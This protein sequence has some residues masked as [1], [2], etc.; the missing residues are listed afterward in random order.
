MK[1]L[2]LE[3]EP[4][5]RRGGQ[6]LSL[7][8]VCRGLAGHGHQIDL[9]YTCEG[10]LLEQYRTFCRSLIKVERYTVDRSNPVSSLAGVARGL[11]RLLPAD[12]DL[13]YFNQYHDAMFGGLLARM[14]RLPLV[15]HLRLFPPGTFCGQWRTG[16]PAVTRFIAVS[17]ATR[18]AYIQAGFAPETI[19]VVYNGIDL[20]R[21]ALADDWQATRAALGITPDAFVVIYVGRIDRPKN[22]E[23]IIQAFS[24]LKIPAAG[25]RLVIVGGALVH[26]TEEAG[27]LYIE[28]L[29]ELARSLGIEREVQWLG[30]RNDIPKLFRA[31]DVSVLPSMLPETFGRSI[32]ES[33]ACGTPAIGVS[34]GGVPEILTG[35]F[36]RYCVENDN[37]K[38]MVDALTS[39]QDWRQ[40]D[41]PLGMR[42]REH[43]V[44]RFDAQRMADEVH[45]VLERARHASH[46][47]SG[48]STAVL[49]AWHH[50]GVDYQT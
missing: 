23:M 47:R 31:A 45:A 7:L 4:S 33:M 25:K 50:E 15:C 11:F 8:D 12:T 48:P 41:P 9:V 16:L 22:I 43:T 21:F 26:T 39:L 28:E 17:E 3:N 2:V 37:L 34:L 36:S 29:K 40:D 30:R 14:K 32:A 35:E 19:D 27:E 44:E 18:S 46:I 1:I 42:C 49:K 6:E 20:R 13:I 10:D 24:M 5:S 38:G